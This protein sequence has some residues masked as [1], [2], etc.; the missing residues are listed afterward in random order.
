M[1][2]VPPLP[3]SDSQRIQGSP[4]NKMAFKDLDDK[5][6]RLMRSEI[7]LD[8]TNDG[9]YRSTRMDSRHYAAYDEMLLGA[10]DSG[11]PSTLT[12]EINRRRMRCRVAA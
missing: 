3:S 8:T 5:T 10:A 1:Y 12:R 6:R 4:I 11:T 9:I 2:G 7:E